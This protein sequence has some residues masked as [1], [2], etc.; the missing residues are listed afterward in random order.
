MIDIEPTTDGVLL[1]VRAQPGAR[2]NGVVGVHDGRLK[3]AVTQ[4]REKGK[5]NGAI[6]KV[7]AAA[8]R[9]K[10]SQIELVGGP[11]SSQKKFRVTGLTVGELRDRIAVL[12]GEN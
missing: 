1:P 2:K 6:K 8:L 10:K 11:T 9:L 12:L 7:L 3:V 5:A 4:A